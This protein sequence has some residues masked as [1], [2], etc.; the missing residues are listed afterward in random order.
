MEAETVFAIG[1]LIFWIAL[2]VFL[3]IG[4]QWLRNRERDTR[5]AQ[6]A[7]LTAHLEVIGAGRINRRQ[8]SRATGCRVSVYDDFFVVSVS[9]QRI[10]FPL[11]RVTDIDTSGGLDRLTL[12]AL[13]EDESAISIDFR[14]ASAAELAAWLREH[15]RGTPHPA[16]RA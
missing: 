11:Y 13:G 15:G 1:F 9:S 14:G 4:Y 10:A 7:G 16:G 6:E 3:V 12:R 8:W 5:L 2:A